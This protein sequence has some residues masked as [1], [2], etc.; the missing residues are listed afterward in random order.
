MIADPA[1]YL[2][3]DALIDRDLINRRRVR[4]TSG[5]H[6]SPVD[7]RADLRVPF[8]DDR[9]IRCARVLHVHPARDP[10]TRHLRYLPERVQLRG[11]G[12]RD[13]QLDR[14][15]TA[16]RVEPRQ[17]STGTART[18]SRREHDRAHDPDQQH[19]HDDT[20]PTTP[21]SQIRPT[22]KPRPRHLPL[23]G[24]GKGTNN[25]A[26]RRHHRIPDHDPYSTP[27]HPKATRWTSTPISGVVTP[28]NNSRA[29]RPP[30]ANAKSRRSGIPTAR[31]SGMRVMR[32]VFAGLALVW[33]RVGPVQ[34]WILTGVPT[35]A[36]TGEIRWSV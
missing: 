33:R 19:Q 13:L 9:Q 11:R 28:K 20:A 4:G 14:R 2:R 16:R 10:E 30:I 32:Q 26:S 22:A 34:G 27:P 23:R 25:R 29:E 17:R 36:P 18:S 7:H 35:K 15:C 1:V 12:T 24:A 5:D 21:E 3:G 8:R 31:R 6:P